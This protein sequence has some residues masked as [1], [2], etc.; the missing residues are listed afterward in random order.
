MENIKR[1][2]SKMASKRGVHQHFDKK[3][4]AGVKWLDGLSY[5]KKV[6]LGV[7]EGARHAYAPGTMRFQLKTRSGVKLRAFSDNG[8]A[9]VYI[10]LDSGYYDEF[11]L[12]LLERWPM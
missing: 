4:K 9:D 11:L 2:N 10:V 6:I 3:L 5:V 8:V 7:C 12:K 1:R